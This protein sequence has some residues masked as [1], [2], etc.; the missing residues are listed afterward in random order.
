M[1]SFGTNRKY[2]AGIFVE[3]DGAEIAVLGRYRYVL[4]GFGLNLENDARIYVLLLRLQKTSAMAHRHIRGGVGFNNHSIAS[5]R[6]PHDELQ[7]K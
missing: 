6:H 5:L 1:P 7:I 2:V 3:H 4:V